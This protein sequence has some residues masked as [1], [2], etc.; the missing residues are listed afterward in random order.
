MTSGGRSRL[1]ESG[2]EGVAQS[3]LMV[4]ELIGEAEVDRAFSESRELA[5]LASAPLFETRATELRDPGGQR[6]SFVTNRREQKAARSSKQSPTSG[7]S[8]AECPLRS[9]SSDPSFTWIR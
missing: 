4:D 2:P 1:G 8:G 7:P 5:T 9:L 3:G 6:S